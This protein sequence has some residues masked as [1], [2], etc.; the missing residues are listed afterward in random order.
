[1]TLVPLL[2]NLA[3]MIAVL[4]ALLSVVGVLVRWKTPQRRGHVIRLL[5]AIMAIPCLVGI[6]FAHL[7]LIVLPEIGRQQRAE[8]DSRRTE[9]IADS[10]R[11]HVGDLAPRFSL[12][13]ADGEK[14]SLPENGKVCVINFFATWCAPCRLELPHINQI[15]TEHQGNQDF[16]LLVIGREEST[17]SVRQYR[18]QHGY[19]FPIAADPKQE[20]YSQFADSIIPRT[21][22]VSREGRVVYSSVGFQESDLD[23][24]NTVLQQQLSALGADAR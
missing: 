6:H 18:A 4:I 13:T 2:L 12:I 23:G 20:V 16:R 1:M 8:N 15:W 14:V 24:F 5:L 21:L 11:V 10:T 17:D 19:S 7:F 9:E 22:I 3:M